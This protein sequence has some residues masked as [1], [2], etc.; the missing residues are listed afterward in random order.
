MLL[1]ILFDIAVPKT[2]IFSLCILS[3]ML[4]IFFLGS[5]LY[6]L[7]ASCDGPILPVTATVVCV[8]SLTINQLV[9]FE[10]L[11]LT[12]RQFR[13]AQLRRELELF[14]SRVPVPV[15]DSRLAA[16]GGFAY[17]FSCSMCLVP[18][19]HGSFWLGSESTTASSC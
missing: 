3:A 7:P 6:R 19:G 9:W 4:P 14:L 12:E 15:G 8:V 5:L 18:P 2:T 17:R 10:Q 11:T 16:I 1:A 13:G